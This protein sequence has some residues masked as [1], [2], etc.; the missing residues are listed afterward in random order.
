MI[1]DALENASLYRLL[2][3]RLARA[4]DF[5]GTEEAAALEPPAEGIENA[6]RHDIEGDDIFA[7]VQRYRP[8]RRKNGRWEAHRRYIDVQC[9]VEGVESIGFAPM[10]L[11]HRR[12]YDAERDVMKTTPRKPGFCEVAVA[13]GHFAILMP[14]DAHMP[15]L[16]YKGVFGVV[17]KIVVKVRA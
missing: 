4:L 13:A 10:G 5:L 17:K 11:M 14:H 3:P 2:S 16:P 7:L 8:K 1:L 15:G 9:V 6:L 12:P